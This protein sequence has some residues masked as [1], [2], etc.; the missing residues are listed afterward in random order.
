MWR[1]LLLTF[2]ILVLCGFILYVTIF[3]LDPMGEQKYI[4][5][6]ALG[7]SILFGIWSFFT[8]FFFFGA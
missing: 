6:L 4:A 8:L 7:A 1:N 3:Q 5:Y 2:I